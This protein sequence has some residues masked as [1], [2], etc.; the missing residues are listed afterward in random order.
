MVV[1]Y[2]CISYPIP[3]SYYKINNQTGYN[4]KGAIHG[5][6]L[7]LG[8]CKLLFPALMLISMLS[9]RPLSGCPISRVTSDSR[10]HQTNR[11]SNIKSYLEPLPRIVP[12]PKFSRRAR[13]IDCSTNLRKSIIF[14]TFK[15]STLY[16]VRPT[17]LLCLTRRKY[18]RATVI[19][20]RP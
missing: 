8:K 13:F 9:G 3:S 7:D 5:P 6:P 19:L 15:M 11:Q 4:M 2:G 17:P 12:A 18:C 20:T 14:P 1:V 16:G 10:G